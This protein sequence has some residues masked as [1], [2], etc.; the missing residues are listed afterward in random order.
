MLVLIK[1]IKGD[2]VH[3][4]RKANVYYQN[5]NDHLAVALNRTKQDD[6]VSE[7]ILHQIQAVPFVVPTKQSPLKSLRKR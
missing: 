3:K 7:K 2:K 5:F 1:T 6:A 4:E